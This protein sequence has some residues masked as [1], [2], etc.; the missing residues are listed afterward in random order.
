LRIAVSEFPDAAADAD[1]GW[2]VL[3]HKL[4]AAPVDLLILPELAGA[5]SIWT[6]P[7]FDYHMQCCHWFRNEAELTSPVSSGSL[8]RPIAH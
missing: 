3:E 5:G 8:F 1:A 2:T 7:M 4:K 6:G